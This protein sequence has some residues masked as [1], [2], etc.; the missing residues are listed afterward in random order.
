VDRIAQRRPLCDPEA[1]HK[2]LRLLGRRE[3]VCMTQY[4]VES[5]GVVVHRGCERQPGELK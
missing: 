3:V 1:P 2:E 4:F 5:S